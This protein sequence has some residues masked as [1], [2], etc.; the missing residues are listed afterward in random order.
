LDSSHLL[1]DEYSKAKQGIFLARFKSPYF[2]AV[3][4]KQPL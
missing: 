2:Q 3:F 1:C 4:E